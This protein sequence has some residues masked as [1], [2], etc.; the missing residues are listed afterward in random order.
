MTALKLRPILPVRA[1]DGPPASAAPPDAG[2]RRHLRLF[3]PRTHRYRPVR[4]DEVIAGVL[5]SHKAVR[6]Q[7]TNP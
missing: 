2:G 7:L 4:H 3:V 1:E 6:E 5:L